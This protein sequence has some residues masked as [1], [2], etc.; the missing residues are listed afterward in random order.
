MKGVLAVQYEADVYSVRMSTRDRVS[1]GKKQ[2]V[3]GKRKGTRL[4]RKSRKEHSHNLQIGWASG[5]VGIVPDGQ[6]LPHTT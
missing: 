6:N 4:P 3:R 1:Y 5:G 2:G